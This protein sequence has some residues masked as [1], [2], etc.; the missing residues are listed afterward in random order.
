ME[1]LSEITK[2]YIDFS[3]YEDLFSICNEYIGKKNNNETI[4]KLVK[5]CKLELH[6]MFPI[7]DFNITWK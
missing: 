6:S 4:S 5:D 3:I 2:K 7:E 1:I